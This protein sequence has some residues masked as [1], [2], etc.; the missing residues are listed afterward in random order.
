MSPLRGSGLLRI[1]GLIIFW[2]YL[3]FAKETGARV[4][5]ALAVPCLYSGKRAGNPLCLSFKRTRNKS[6]PAGRHMGRKRT[7][8]NLACR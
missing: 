5:A 3:L 4:N 6:V 8:N 1:G 7:K 2:V